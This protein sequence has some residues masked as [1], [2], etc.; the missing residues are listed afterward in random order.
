MLRGVAL[1]AI[2]VI[3]NVREFTTMGGL[4]KA[5]SSGALRSEIAALRR[6]SSTIN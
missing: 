3:H 1:H 2:P 5:G 4:N 6:A